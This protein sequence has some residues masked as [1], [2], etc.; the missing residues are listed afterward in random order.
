MA[1]VELSVPVGVDALQVQQ[2]TVMSRTPGSGAVSC[3]KSS[4]S[5]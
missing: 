1:D 5:M 4:T 2:P 3:C